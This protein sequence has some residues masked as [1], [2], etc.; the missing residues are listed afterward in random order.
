MSEEVFNTIANNANKNDKISWNRKRK[1]M[2]K[3]IAD[4]ISPLE[5][6]ILEL[7]MRKMSEM[8]TVIEIRDE[9][10]RECIHPKDELVKKEGYVLCKFCQAKLRV[11]EKS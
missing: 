3:M 7:T 9:L 2:R 8:D 10:V 1:K 11:N 4:N 6:Q 5:D